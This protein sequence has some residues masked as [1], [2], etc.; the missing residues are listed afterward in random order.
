MANARRP[1]LA[2]IVTLIVAHAKSQCK[3]NELCELENTLAISTTSLLIPSSSVYPASCPGVCSQRADCMAT[4]FDPETGICELHEAYAD[5]A[6][7]IALS[8]KM[9]P[10]FSMMNL[11]GIPC[12]KVRHGN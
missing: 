5:G 10:T 2:L 7:C 8:A 3:T 12:P 11:P 1:S 9:G 4:T 6:P